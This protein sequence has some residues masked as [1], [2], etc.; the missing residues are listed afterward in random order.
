MSSNAN[1]AL[2]GIIWSRVP[3]TVFVAKETVEMGAHSAV[4]HYNDGRKGVLNVLQYFGLQ[5]S[6]SKITAED[7]DNSRVIRV[8]KKS[9]D[10]SKKRRKGLRPI[11]KGFDDKLNENEPVDSYEAGA[12]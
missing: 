8:N 10:A 11:K 5:G 2:N 3:K 4:I 6:I 12:Y 7:Q 1:E 9:S